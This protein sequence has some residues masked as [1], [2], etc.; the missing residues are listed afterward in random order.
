MLR[1]LLNSAISLGIIYLIFF[2]TK[3]TV[4]AAWLYFLFFI[5][6]ISAFLALYMLP[7]EPHKMYL[8][9]VRRFLIQPILLL[10]FVPAFY[11]QKL[12]SR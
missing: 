5:L 7:D 9:Y 4:F 12:H 10:L 11:F 3:L 6:L 1:Y 2:D 8:F